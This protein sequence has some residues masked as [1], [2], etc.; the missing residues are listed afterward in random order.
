MTTPKQK[1]G[2]SK[3]NYGTPDDFLDAVERR[4]GA[5][6]FDLA[7]DDENA[8]CE[9]YYTKEQDSL[10][11]DWSILKGNLWLNPPFGHIKP[12]AEK[13]SDYGY[14]K[15]REL[16]N[17]KGQLLFLTPASVGANWFVE[18]VFMQSHVIFL[19]GRIT[20]VGCKD[21]Y[22]KDCILSVFGKDK[23]GFSVW[24]WRK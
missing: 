5:I 23:T 19:Q 20:F 15:E 9:N 14:E 6:H 18:N 22:P 11:Q 21:S 8:V 17:I 4:F 3:Q 12:W 16:I 10:K 7:A 1:P 13:C 2:R 24:D